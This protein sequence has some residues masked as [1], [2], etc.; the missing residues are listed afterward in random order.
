MACIEPA[1]DESLAAMRARI[2]L[3]IAMAAITRIIATTIN[4]SISE[5]P[6]CFVMEFI[7]YLALSP[8]KPPRPGRTTETVAL[9]RPSWWTLTPYGGYHFSLDGFSR[10]EKDKGRRNSHPAALWLCTLP[11]FAKLRYFAKFRYS[12]NGPC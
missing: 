4:S 9:N 3:G 1:A 12:P 5:K 6:F 2:R 7:R 8:S 10:P 11:Y